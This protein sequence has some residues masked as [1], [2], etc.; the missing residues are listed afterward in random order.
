MSKNEEFFQSVGANVIAPANA[1]YPTD[2]IDPK[3]IAAGSKRWASNQSTYWGAEQ[4]HDQIP[5]GVYKS[6]HSPEYGQ[7]LIKIPVEADDIVPLPGNE[8]DEIVKEFDDFWSLE[9]Q[10]R[11]RG[12]LH[13]RGFL[14]WGLQE[15]ERRRQYN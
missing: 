7:V 2:S 13:K 15:A 14:L 10:F 12:F 9:K 1:P 11:S 3:K 8:G 4:T 6:G 5:P